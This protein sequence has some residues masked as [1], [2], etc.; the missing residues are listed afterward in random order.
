MSAL[1]PLRMPS[2]QLALIIMTVLAK[3]MLVV[4]VIAWCIAVAAWLHAAR[5]WFPMAAVRFR[6]TDWR[7][8]NMRWALMG[9]GIFVAA[10]AVGFVAGGIA[11][12]WGGGW[13]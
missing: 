7:E 8:T 11:E 1:T 9:Y 4:F 10:I 5:Y 13:Q 6:K 2:P 3:A 12:Y